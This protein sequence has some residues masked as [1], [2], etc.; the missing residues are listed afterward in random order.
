VRKWFQA[1]QLVDMTPR[2]GLILMPRKNTTCC[3][4][5]CHFLRHTIIL[6]KEF[7]QVKQTA[8]TALIAGQAEITATAERCNKLRSSQAT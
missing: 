3:T 5:L 1:A 2:P 8:L 4:E 7:L 6:Q